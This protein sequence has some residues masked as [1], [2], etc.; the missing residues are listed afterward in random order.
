MGYCL[1]GTLLAVAAAF[2]AR[3]HDHRLN[4][5]TLL[6]SEIDFTEPGEL[7]LFIDEG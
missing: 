5:L 7:G 3:S 2:M 6:A 1:G 4:S